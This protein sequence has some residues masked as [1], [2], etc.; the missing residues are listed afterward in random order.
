MDGVT[1]F[2][3]ATVAFTPTARL[4]SPDTIRPSADRNAWF[5]WAG[6]T[7]G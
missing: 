1:V 7:L 2:R 6:T 4:L 3:V 5:A